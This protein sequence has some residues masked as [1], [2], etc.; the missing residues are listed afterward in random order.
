MQLLNGE[1]RKSIN[2][3]SSNY[4]WIEGIGSEDGPLYIAV[5]YCD[6][7][8][9]AALNCFTENDTLKYKN[10]TFNSC[11]FSNVGFNENSKKLF[12]LSPNPSSEFIKI[13]TNYALKNASIHLKDLNG[14]ELIYQ[15]LNHSFEID[16]SMLSN[17]FYILHL[18]ENDEFVEAIKMMVLKK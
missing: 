12:Y 3:Y 18:Y 17:G 9:N 15:Q 16:V 14:K 13:N 7:D 5:L 6:V 8:F 11:Y 10:T 4:K 2:F 1:F